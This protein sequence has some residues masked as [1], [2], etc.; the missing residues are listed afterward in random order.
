MIMKLKK[1]LGDAVNQG[2]EVE[3]RYLQLF[4]FFPKSHNLFKLICQYKVFVYSIYHV[5]RVCAQT[6]V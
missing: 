2:K 4:M 5:G 1:K 3:S 6:L